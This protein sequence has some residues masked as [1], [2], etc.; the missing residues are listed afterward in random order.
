VKCD[1]CHRSIA[2]GVDARKMICEY[3]QRDGTAKVFGYM[4]PAGPLIEA[5]GRLARGWHHKCWHIVR[6][7]SAKGDAVTGRVLPAIPTAYEIATG[8]GV[9]RVAALREAVADMQALA[10]EVGKPVGDPHVHEAHQ[11]KL[12]GG[13]YEHTHT[14]R[15]DS[16]Q[17]LGHLTYAHGTNRTA[18][19][20]SKLPLH[21]EHD[22]LHAQ[23]AQRRTE[24]ART[25]D[26]GY[27]EPIEHDWREQRVAEL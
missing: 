25:E 16:Y 20:R 27:A 23:A 24:L 6:K 2:S 19:G 15:L 18:S 21:E 12:H 8:E 13:P 4:M 9:E 10:R 1:S 26:P 11:A 7:R 5:T 14:M 22:Q 17:L 3:Q